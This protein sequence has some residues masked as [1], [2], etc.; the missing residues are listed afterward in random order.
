M[1]LDGLVSFA[2]KVAQ[3]CEDV[4]DKG[5]MPEHYD[6]ILF[7]GSLQFFDRP[8]DAINDAASCLSVTPEGKRRGRI[9]VS[10]AQGA[11]FVREEKQGNPATVP[12]KMP[13]W[14]EVCAL[15]KELKMKVTRPEDH[16]LESFY[17]VALDTC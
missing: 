17:L 16:H 9:V 7:N 8:L 4:L 13:D 6:T 14:K 10:H 3:K 15:A 5:G 2:Q 11:E 12:S 1:I